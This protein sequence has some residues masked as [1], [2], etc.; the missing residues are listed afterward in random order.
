[1]AGLEHAVEESGVRRV[2]FIPLFVHDEAIGALAVFK[3]RPRPYRE[4]E[5]GLLLA[6]SSQLAVV[7]QNARLHEHA[8]ELSEVLE[9]TLES[10]RRAARQLRGLYAVWQSFTESLSLEATLAAVAE[11]MVGASRGRRGGDPH[12]GSP[13][14]GVDGPRGTRRR[15]ARGGGR[16]RLGGRPAT[17]LGATGPTARAL[18]ARGRAPSRN[19][20]AGGRPPGARAVPAPGG[21]GGGAPAR[22]ARRGARD[23]DGRLVRPRTAARAERDRGGDRGR[24]AGRARDRQRAPLPAAEGLRGDDAAVAPPARASPRRGARR[25][26]RL[27]VVGARRRRRRPLRLRRSSRTGASRS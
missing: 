5:E 3:K 9:R 22:D 12:A 8:K 17:A 18:E 13:E 4:G 11:A 20:P 2:L 15:P 19:G 27:P 26:P 7:V 21:D 24:C 16:R 25:R 23:A 14:R 10:E 1:M 6:L